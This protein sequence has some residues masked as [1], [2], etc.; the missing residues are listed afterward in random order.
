MDSLKLEAKEKV[1]KPCKLVD[2]FCFFFPTG[3]QLT[4]LI[5]SS[6]HVHE[7]ETIE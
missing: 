1:H 3:I 5:V 7:H 6:I 4:I 2:S